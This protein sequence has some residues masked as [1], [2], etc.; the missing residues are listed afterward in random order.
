M[1]RVLL[2]AAVLLAACT[3][4]TDTRAQPPP[5]YP[6]ANPPA[7]EPVPIAN[8]N[9]AQS[10][11]NRVSILDPKIS[12]A[13][14]TDVFQQS[15]ALVDV[16]WVVSNAGTMAD[17]RTRLANAVS[18]FIDVLAGS[19]VDWQMA[20]TSSDLS[21]YPLPGDGGTHT[22]DGGQLHGPVPII[23]AQDPTYQ[24]D[25]LS[26][27]TWD[28]ERD[29]APC[30]DLDLRNRCNCPRR[31]GARAAQRRGSSAPAPRWR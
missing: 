19:K 15:S 4:P 24:A 25:F 28:I 31:P 1:R 5:L 26:A 16:L 6:Q 22:G 21:V 11:V 7:L 20:V 9:L 27:L 30:A 14:Q 10:I 3:S 29:S 12:S 2:L 23:T 8:L 18:A 17:E 13:L